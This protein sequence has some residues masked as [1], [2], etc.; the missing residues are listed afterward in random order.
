LTFR[1]GA[2]TALRPLR[3]RN[4]RLY[5]SGQLV[6]LSGTWMQTAGLAWL[7][8]ALTGSGTKL[9]LVTAS[10]FVP[11]LLG[12]AW[13]GLLADRLDKQRLLIYTQS[14]LGATATGLAALTLSGGIEVW[15]LVAL[16]VLTGVFTT[17]DN[18]TRQS[19]VTEVVEPA[20]LPTAVALNSVMF[21]SARIVGPAVAAVIISAFGSDVERGTG[22][23]F[24]ANAVSYLAVIVCL[25]RMR[26][27]ELRPAAPVARAK[28]Q[29]RAGI[30]YALQVPALR[31]ILSM[32]AL[33]GLLAFNYQVLLPL[34]AKEVFHGNARTYGLLSVAMGS[35]ALV[36]SLAAAGR[37][38]TSARLITG[39]AT[40]LGVCMLGAAAAPVLIVALVAWCAVGAAMMTLMA[41]ASTTLQLATRP[42]M[43]GRVIAL[44]MLLLM[45]S[46]PIGGPI[47]GWLAEHAGTRWALALGGFACLAAAV[48]SLQAPAQLS[49][50]PD[51]AASPRPAS[52][53][54]FW[55]NPP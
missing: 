49:P 31:T 32:M 9:G 43:R 39:G 41:A 24:A 1:A 53:R 29:I 34:V 10:Q 20:D 48:V 30:S 46:T 55:P 25:L 17:L 6:S 19:F 15:M 12:S 44:Y 26:T 7:V 45:G 36:G 22:I 27:S 54:R 42:D 4:Y 50:V 2:Q 47:M 52:P 40:V 8:L 16:S 28:G 51:D 14:G 3:Q 38:R 5:F 13:G 11:T 33:I 18:P 37:G 23:C 21:N 35:G